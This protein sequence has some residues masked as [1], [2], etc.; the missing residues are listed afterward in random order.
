MK[1]LKSIIILFYICC[2]LS[3]CSDDDGLYRCKHKI[4]ND[5]GDSLFLKTA[6]WGVTGNS[7]IFLIT[8]KSDR[9][10]DISDFD[11]TMDFVYQGYYPIYIKQKA[12]SIIVYTFKVLPYP[13]K[14]NTTFKIKQIEINNSQSQDLMH[15]T[16]YID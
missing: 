10:N 7:R 1:V 14:I 6:Y 2:T 12:D 13:Q 5:R 8:T 15:D 16:T 4:I 3:S 11:S 9:I